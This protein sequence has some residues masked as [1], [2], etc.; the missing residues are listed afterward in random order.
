MKKII[1]GSV[2]V[3]SIFFGFVG[4]ISACSYVY[5]TPQETYDQN[6]HVFIGKISNISTSGGINGNRE[7]TF[8]VLQTY[9]GSLTGTVTLTTGANSAM[10][11]YDDGALVKGDIWSIHTSVK[12]S[13][14]SLPHNQKYESLTKAQGALDPLADNEEPK[15][16]TLQYAPVCGQ[17]DTGIRCVTTPCPSKEIK[18]Y[19]NLCQ[20][21]VD[22]AE[23]LYEGECR[24]DSKPPVVTNPPQQ[25]SPNQEVD[26]K[27]QESSNDDGMYPVPTD[28]YQ[29]SS[30]GQK[31]L[32]SVTRFFKWL[33]WLD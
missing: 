29:D 19:G 8:Q 33:F 1:M 6:E 12:D 30:F 9:K 14:N 11:G 31:I 22:K 32:E 7:V 23:Y 13:F 25:P 5:Q 27:S 26:S 10:C 20:L 28:T 3:L 16:C 2:I 18:T 17:K 4:S 21:N 24:S 15:F